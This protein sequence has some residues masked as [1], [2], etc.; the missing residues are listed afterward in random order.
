MRHKLIIFFY[1]L[2]FYYQSYLNNKQKFFVSNIVEAATQWNRKNSP[3]IHSYTRY[4]T[5]SKNRNTYGLMKPRISVFTLI[6]TFD[7]VTSNDV[8]GPNIYRTRN[9]FVCL[10]KHYSNCMIDQYFVMNYFMSWNFTVPS[11]YLLT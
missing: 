4:K 9:N 8:E 11:V 7:P 5:V 6:E 2:N 1:I 10:F 3:K